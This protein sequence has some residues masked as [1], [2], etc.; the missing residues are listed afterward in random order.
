MS[1]LLKDVAFTIRINT[2]F[3]PQL[4][5]EL[6]D[7]DNKSVVVSLPTSTPRQSVRVSSSSNSI[8]QWIHSIL[9]D[10]TVVR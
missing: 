8:R 5:L 7:K 3:G 1:G 2:Q 6:S 4:A 9:V 10:R